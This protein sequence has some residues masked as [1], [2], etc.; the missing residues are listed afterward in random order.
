MKI[1][2]RNIGH[3]M[4]KHG[5]DL[6]GTLEI[7]GPES[8]PVIDAMW[9]RAGYPG[10]DDETEW[11]GVAMAEIVRRC[12]E[13]PIDSSYIYE[14]YR[15]IDSWKSIYPHMGHSA[16]EK[17][18]SEIQSLY[19]HSG[20]III[21]GSPAWARSWL[22]FGQCVWDK[23]TYEGLIASVKPGDVC[24]F[25]RGD[26]GHVGLFW[27]WDGTT[28][29]KVLGGNQDN[30]VLIKPYPANRLLGIRRAVISKP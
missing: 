29:I 6:L 15:A 16:T 9:R 21:P 22:K 8:N 20:K 25:E 1:S 4:L 11:C 13:P 5:L 12:M 30:S 27:G 18:L 14:V 19:I 10:L 23:K 7:P 24:I 26:G 28:G 3:M 2:K 17:V